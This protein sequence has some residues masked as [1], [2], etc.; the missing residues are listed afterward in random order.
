METD[1]ESNRGITD[2]DLQDEESIDED[3]DNNAINN[4]PR[5][6]ELMNAAIPK[7]TDERKLSACISHCP[8]KNLKIHIPLTNPTRTFSYLLWEDLINQSSK[9]HNAQGKKVHI[10]KTKLRHAEKMIRGALIELFKGL[11]YLKTY[12]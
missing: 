8:G 1:E 4:L 11:G 7:K 10:N 2:Q 3:L 6:E 12:R 5:S 9:K